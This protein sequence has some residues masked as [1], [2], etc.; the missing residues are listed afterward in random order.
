MIQTHEVKS[1]LNKQKKR[2]GWFLTEYSVNPYEGCSCN[3]LYCY[4]RGSKYGENMAEKLSAKLNALAVLDKQLKNRAAK[5]EYGFVALGSATDAYI[6]HEANFRITEGA[7]NLFLKYKFPVFISTKRDLIL[8]DI[9]LLKQI[10]KAAILPNDLRHRLK[11]G[12]ILSISIST[13][14]EHICSMLEPGACTPMER[15]GVLKQLKSAGFLVGVNAIPILPFISDTELE[16]QKIVEA[17]VLHGADYIL[18]GGLTLFGKGV[19]DSKT[20]YNKFLE[21][22]KPSLIPLYRELFKD[23]DFAPAMYH[24][25]LKIKSDRLCAKYKIR[26]R[27]LE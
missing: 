1:V 20:L 23:N 19:A 27:I 8:R 2:D 14:D 6:P 7:L 9:E 26:N 18:V 13:M 25:A 12:T 11:G 24:S 21:R 15:L 5:S 4:I 17:A 22:Y 10:N 16:M 3:C